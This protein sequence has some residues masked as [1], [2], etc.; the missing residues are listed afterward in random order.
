M[1]R[2]QI[3]LPKNQK[4]VLRERARKYGTTM[5]AVI[6]ELIDH[7][8]RE[9]QPDKQ[10]KSAAANSMFAVLEK[11]K[12]SGEKGPPDLAVNHDKYLYGGK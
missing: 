11:I 6:R 7:G 1:K 2:T 12:K 8:L 9:A 4:D 3:Y 10:K 5:S